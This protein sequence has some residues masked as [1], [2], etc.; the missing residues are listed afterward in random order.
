MIHNRILPL[1]GRHAK[2]QGHQK[3]NDHGINRQ[4]NRGLGAV[5]E[6]SRYGLV[7]GHAF[8]EVPPQHVADPAPV[9][10][11]QRIVDAHFHPK[12]FHILLRGLVAQHGAGRIPGRKMYDGEDDQGYH[13]QDGQDG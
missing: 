3:R 10:H 11:H 2:G 13:Q 6:H 5:A 7:V 8:A 1:G 9:L 4:G 12:R